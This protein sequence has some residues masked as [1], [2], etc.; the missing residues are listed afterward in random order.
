MSKINDL[1]KI[2]ELANKNNGFVTTK[3]VVQNNLN[4]MALKRLC[5]SNKLERI[6][7]GYYRLPNA[8]VDD[9]YKVISK[10]KQTVYSHATALYLHDLSDRTPLRFDIT[11]PRGYGAH[12]KMII[13][14]R[15]IM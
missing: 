9:F 8:L 10:S 7:V 1:E 13:M 11:V 5:D 15:Y 4:K 12:F 6:S 3:E 2:L 14:F